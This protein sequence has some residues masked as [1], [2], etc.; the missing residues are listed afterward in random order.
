MSLR[1]ALVGV[2]VPA[3]LA[4]CVTPP[5]KAAPRLRADAPVGAPLPAAAKPTPWPAS[6]WWKAFGDPQLDALI[7]QGLAASPSLVT[8]RARI[9]AAD[10][11]VAMQLAQSG[12]RL[13]AS[14]G[15]ARQR[16]SDNGLISGRLLNVS[17]YT[18]ADAALE[19]AADFDWWG[20][21][22]AGIAAALHRS[23]AA[24]AEQKAAE[25]ILSS[26]IATQYLGWQSGRAR[27]DLARELVATLD[28]RHALQALRVAREIDPPESLDALE[29]ERVQA[30]DLVTVY[31]GIVYNQ[32]LAL[33]ALLGVAP[34]RVDLSKRG[35]ATVPLLLQPDD[36]SLRLIARRPDLVA[37]RWRVEASVQDV[38]QA[39]A[40]YYPDVRLRA[41]GGL[42]STELSDFLDS[43]SRVATLGVSLYL[44]IFDSRN[45][46]ARHGVRRAELE[47]AVASYHE[48]VVAAANE[49]AYEVSAWVGSSARQKHARDRVAVTQA[50]Q[51]AVLARGTSGVDDA[52]AELSAAADVLRARDA[53]AVID[54]ELAMHQV[55]LIK[56]LGGG[57]VAP[58]ADQSD[59]QVAKR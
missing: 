39:R 37:S 33:A 4:G 7:A 16:I 38:A 1:I 49:V 5:P 43:G 59:R 13:G 50:L 30:R 3:L 58:P 6:T 9:D 40:G 42:S 54:G 21:Q 56:A 55:A 19:L 11:A 20:R 10:A 12:V 36:V 14:V 24:Q 52:R 57:Y 46:K 44:P 34:D 17:W 53:L 47:L 35:R 51:K 32:Q 48:Q 29:L 22:K 23:A 8:A 41:L 18:Q 26:A 15:I 45:V 27:E 31:G 25:L 28:R 2:L